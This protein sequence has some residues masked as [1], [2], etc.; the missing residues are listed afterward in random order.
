MAGSGQVHL[1]LA[2]QQGAMVTWATAKEPNLA[3]HAASDPHVV[4]WYQEDQVLDVVIQR[5][6]LRQVYVP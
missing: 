3:L 2:Y 1:S 4:R 5:P 6:Y